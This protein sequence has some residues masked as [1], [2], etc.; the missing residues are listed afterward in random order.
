M[1]EN[2]IKKMNLPF[3]ETV[4]VSDS[5]MNGVLVQEVLPD[6]YICPTDSK[7]IKIEGILCQN[8]KNG[9][10]YSAVLKHSKE[11]S[12]T[13]ISFVKGSLNRFYNEYMTIR[14]N[15][16]DC[17]FRSAK[18]AG[19]SIQFHEKFPEKGVAD[20]GGLAYFYADDS[21]AK[22]LNFLC[23][24]YG[25]N[26]PDIF[27]QLF[28]TECS[29][30]I[31]AHELGH[32][33]ML[34]NFID[35]KK[36]LDVVVN[37]QFGT[38]WT[39]ILLFDGH[40]A[41]PIFD[42]ARIQYE[43]FKRKPHWTDSSYPNFMS[44]LYEAITENYPTKEN[45]IAELFAYTL[46]VAATSKK[47]LSFWNED[48]IHRLGVEN[49]IDL[50]R[51]CAASDSKSYALAKD[52]IK[53]FKFSQKIKEE[54][55]ELVVFSDDVESGGIRPDMFCLAEYDRRLEKIKK[56]FRHENNLMRKKINTKLES[57][58][59]NNGYVKRILKSHSDF[60]SEVNRQGKQ[61]TR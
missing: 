1:A 5:G 58:K 20:R 60:L 34:E 6:F 32:M 38:I 56:L 53:N 22:K 43:A 61:F 54:I 9:D 39:D 7:K 18:K 16:L 37:S 14:Q 48:H 27:S 4:L 52:S 45:K 26:E 2:I 51:L 13:D 30:N 46:A 47:G 40:L 17:M 21:G 24:H 23:N 25:K 15:G 28:D 36:C 31:F 33:L 59:K 10:L 50:G 19:L 42:V 44:Q 55:Y 41:S 29:Q 8:V 35:H 49:I 3:K 12:N 57:H 11:A